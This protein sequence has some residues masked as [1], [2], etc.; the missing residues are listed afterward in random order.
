MGPRPGVGPRPPGRARMGP[1]SPG[2][3]RTL[4]KVNPSDQFRPARVRGTWVA[5]TP[6]SV[7]RGDPQ[8]GVD[9][10]AECEAAGVRVGLRGIEAVRDIR[11]ADSVFQIDE[12]E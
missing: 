7:L 2:T 12:P 1:R 9:L 8:G 4:A 6:K 5:R 10:I 3:W 11:V